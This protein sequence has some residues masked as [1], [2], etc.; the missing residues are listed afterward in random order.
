LLTDEGRQS[1]DIAEVQGQLYD[2]LTAQV[3]RYIGVF[4]VQD[5]CL[6]IDH[7]LLRLLTYSERYVL[8][9]ALGGV[10]DDAALLVLFEAAFLDGERIGG[11]RKLGERVVAGVVGGGRLV[12]AVFGAVNRY[13][14]LRNHRTCGVGHGPA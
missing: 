13:S 3:G 6:G 12:N 1:I 4:G 9:S 2:L 10:Q 7:D 8:E 14:R 11:G 5:G